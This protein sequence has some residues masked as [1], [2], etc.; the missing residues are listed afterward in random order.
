VTRHT[1]AHEI[2]LNQAALPIAVAVTVAIV[3]AAFVAGVLV[4]RKFYAAGTIKAQKKRIAVLEKRIEAKAAR[5]KVAE[6]FAEAAMISISR[7]GDAVLKVV[8]SSKKA[9]AE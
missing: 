5:E 8:E 6:A 1:I 9:R 4:H 7:A 3:A 2:S